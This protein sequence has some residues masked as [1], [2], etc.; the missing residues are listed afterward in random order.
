MVLKE[1]IKKFKVL[2]NGQV[3]LKKGQ[4]IKTSGKGFNSAIRFPKITSGVNIFQIRITSDC[5]EKDQM[6]A[7]AFEKP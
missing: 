7:I 3:S 2:G 6:M 5:K 1:A 4:F